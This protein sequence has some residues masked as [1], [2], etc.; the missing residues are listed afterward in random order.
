MPLNPYQPPTAMPRIKSGTMWDVNM[1]NPFGQNYQG[2][3]WKAA[4]PST[5]SSFTPA[6]QTPMYAGAGLLGNMP[7]MGSSYTPADPYA[8]QRAAAAGAAANSSAS[9]AAAG[10]IG[11]QQEQAQ[12]GAMANASGMAGYR[13]SIP[14]P[15][16][17]NTPNYDPGYQAGAFNTQY[18]TLGNIQDYMNPYLD[19]IIER[20]NKNILASASA[21]GL[22]GSTGTENRLGEWATQAQADAYNDAWNRFNTDRGYMTDTYFGNEDRNY[23]NYRDTNAWNYG[24]FTDERND[25][26]ARMADWANQMQ[27]IADTGMNA[28]NTSADVWANYFNALAGLYGEQGDVAAAR[29]M[30]QGNNNSGLLGGLISLLGQFGGG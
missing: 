23:R 22:L 18:G 9:S 10:R 6:A 27:G 7:E 8:A 15:P 14:P 1:G 26:N 21:R 12:S 20:G 16:A 19:Q 4:G 11:Q 25:W 30:Q 28:T 3:M 29:A 5:G 17:M 13:A 2:S 24:L